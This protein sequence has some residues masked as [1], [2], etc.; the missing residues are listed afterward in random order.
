MYI[1]GRV[2]CR[3]KNKITHLYSHYYVGGLSFHI[4]KYS[5]STS[6]QSISKVL[7]ELYLFMLVATTGNAHL[8]WKK[9]NKFCIN[10]KNST[11]T[12]LPYLSK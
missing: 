10:L 5:S 1:Q 2:G 8:F 4:D 6:S 7:E 11:T 9:E 12:Y 3:K